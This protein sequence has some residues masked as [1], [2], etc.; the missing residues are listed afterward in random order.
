MARPSVR[1][2]GLWAIAPSAA[3]TTAKPAET[4]IADISGGFPAV[5]VETQ[6]PASKPR[7]AGPVRPRGR[8]RGPASYHH[9]V[10]KRR[11]PFSKKKSPKSAD[12]TFGTPGTTETP[13]ALRLVAAFIGSVCINV[14]FYRFVR[15]PHSEIAPTG[16][17]WVGVRGRMRFIGT[18]FFFLALASGPASAVNKRP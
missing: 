8:T 9:A 6:P 17:E 3:Q 10:P 5:S 2:V 11:R 14:Q 1:S 13:E 4:H 7:S 18:L 12:Q 16:A 15:P